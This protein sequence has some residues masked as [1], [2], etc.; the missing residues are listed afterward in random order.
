MNT[1]T[2]HRFFYFENRQNAK[3]TIFFEKNAKKASFLT[4]LTQI[5]SQ[6]ASNLSKIANFLLTS[7]AK[8]R[9]TLFVFFQKSFRT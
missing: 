9:I 2:I 4:K 5:F 3:K 8:K 1:D 6:K 7:Q